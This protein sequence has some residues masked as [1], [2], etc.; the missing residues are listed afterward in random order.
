MLILL[1]FKRTFDQKVAGQLA[2][3]RVESY[4]FFDSCGQEVGEKKC[5]LKGTLRH[6]EIY[7]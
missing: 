1:K 4:F 5:Q 3:R 6:L 7:V 2:K